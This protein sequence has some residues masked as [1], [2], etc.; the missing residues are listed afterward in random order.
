MSVLAAAVVALARGGSTI[1]PPAVQNTL[2]EVASEIWSNKY[3][4]QLQFLPL[5]FS[6]DE[7]NTYDIGAT[8]FTDCNTYAADSNYRILVGVVSQNAASEFSGAMYVGNAGASQFEYSIMPDGSWTQELSNTIDICAECTQEQC[9]VFNKDDQTGDFTISKIQYY[10]M[11]YA[12]TDWLDDTSF[13]ENMVTDDTDGLLAL[14]S[15]VRVHLVPCE[16]SMKGHKRIDGLCPG[17]ELARPCTSKPVCRNQGPTISV[18]Q[19]EDDKDTAVYYGAAL[20]PAIKECTATSGQQWLSDSSAFIFKAE[21]AECSRRKQRRTTCTAD[22]QI[23]SDD[24]TS[25]NIFDECSSIDS[26][27]NFGETNG[28]HMHETEAANNKQFALST[29]LISDDAKIINFRATFAIHRLCDDKTHCYDLSKNPK[30][31]IPCNSCT[32]GNDDMNCHLKTC[33]AGERLDNTLCFLCAKGTYMDK[34]GHSDT[35]CTSCPAGKTTA[36]TGSTAQFDCA[37]ESSSASEVA[38]TYL[39]AVLLLACVCTGL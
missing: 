5:T 1:G 7:S 38:A 21:R 2:G 31:C 18:V 13:L 8:H 37:L 23:I 4:A 27:V 29:S 36:A 9:G 26:V 32:N 25:T 30:E 10:A 22:K 24:A 19:L 17:A 14:R 28:K 6:E 35:A 12:G 33:P 34:Q 16:M 39:V 20:S 11:H 3:I 15:A